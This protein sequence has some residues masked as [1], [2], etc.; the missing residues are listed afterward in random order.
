MRGIFDIVIGLQSKG[1]PG[2]GWT[3]AFGV[4]GTLAGWLT[5]RSRGAA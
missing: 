1:R 4:L 2:R 3:I 5:L